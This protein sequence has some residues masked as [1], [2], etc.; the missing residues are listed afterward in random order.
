[1]KC[2]CMAVLVLAVC[3]S[4]AA[5][6]GGIEQAYRGAYGAELYEALV[7]SSRTGTVVPPRLVAHRLDAPGRFVLEYLDPATGQ[8]RRRRTLDGLTSVR[9]C[10][11]GDRVVLCVVSESSGVAL[12]VENADGDT[13]FN[14]R[15]VLD[16]TCCSPVGLYFERLHYGQADSPGNR[17]RVF[18]ADGALLSHMD[19]TWGINPTEMITLPGDSLVALVASVGTV[20]RAAVVVGRHGREVGRRVYDGGV[21]LAGSPAADVFAVGCRGKVDL[22]DA[23]CSVVHHLELLKETRVGPLVAFSP[24]GS[25]LAVALPRVSVPC[26][27]SY[28][29]DSIPGRLHLVDVRTGEVSSTTDFYGH[30]RFLGYIPDGGIVLATGG[31]SLNLYSHTGTLVDAV[32]LPIPV[33]RISTWEVVD[34]FVILGS[35]GESF[36]YRAS[37]GR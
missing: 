29:S 26:I 19:G 1:M 3:F 28:E 22:C 33:S 20:G 27:T 31:P 25:E 24:D 4:H 13:L 21:S 10:P 18:G 37:L 7:A 23:N 15:N 17:I 30:P 6:S 34:R 2:A 12:T 32:R 36:V 16:L 11:T 5:G 9:V 14:L 35:G 8:R